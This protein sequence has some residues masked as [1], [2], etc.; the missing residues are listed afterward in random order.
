[1]DTKVNWILKVSKILSSKYR[2][3]T[4]LWEQM[5]SKVNCYR[6]AKQTLTFCTIYILN[7]L[8]KSY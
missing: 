6:R 4:I 1:M 3:V 8:S 5:D 2:I 7:L